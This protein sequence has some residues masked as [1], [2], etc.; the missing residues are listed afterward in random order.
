AI[1]APGAVDSHHMRRDTALE[2]DAFALA[3]L[4]RARHGHKP[5]ER[6]VWFAHSTAGSRLE[7]AW[8]TVRKLRRYCLRMIFSENRCT[9]FRIMRSAAEHSS[10]TR[11][12]ASTGPDVPASG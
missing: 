8:L 4:G 2:G 1:A 7:A 10:R 6:P 11:P 9:L 3:P 5:F 12:A